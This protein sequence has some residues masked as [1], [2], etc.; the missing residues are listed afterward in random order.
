MF[1]E[2]LIFP[3]LNILFSTFQISL[4]FLSDSWRHLFD[5]NWS[6]KTMKLKECAK[7]LRLFRATSSSTLSWASIDCHNKIVFIII[8]T[9]NTIIIMN[10]SLSNS[11]RT[12]AGTQTMEEFRSAPVRLLLFLVWFLPL[13]FTLTTS[14]FILKLKKTTPFA[15]SLSLLHSSTVLTITSV[16]CYFSIQGCCFLNLFLFFLNFDFFLKFN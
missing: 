1:Y 16:A 4:V 14:I 6:H 13:L 15:I 12:I 10:T 2:L 9:V 8:T 7:L 3:S 11:T 5:F